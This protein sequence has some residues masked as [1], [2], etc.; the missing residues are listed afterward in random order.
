MSEEREDTSYLSRLIKTRNDLAKES[1]VAQSK[2]DAIV[3][4]AK[5]EGRELLN[6]DEDREFRDWVTDIKRLDAEMKAKDE[7]IAE[8]D[9]ERQRKQ[10]LRA[11][12][13]IAERAK[14][15]LDSVT[16]QAVYT[17]HSSRSYF[18]D[19][20]MVAQGRDTSGEAQERLRRHAQDVM[21]LPEYSEYR[22]GLNTTS[23]TGG[24]TVPPAYLLNEY[25]TYA[26]AGRPF[27][28]LVVNEALPDGTMQ[29]NIP[30]MSTGTT[31]A[32]QATQNT[33]V[34]E[35]D[36][37]DSYVTANVFTVAGQQ[38]VSRQLLE[39]SA[40]PVDGLIFR[41]L[42]AA[43][44]TYLD[45]FMYTGSGTNQIQGINNISGI[46]TVAT[47]G[48]TIGYV[49]AAIAN[50]IQLVHSTRFAS[51]DAILM[52]P[53]RWG[54]LTSL[55]DS[56]NR[57][58]FE[59]SAN[60][61]MNAGG[62]LERVAPEARVGQV[63]GVPIIVDANIPTN[64][65]GGTNQDPIYVVRSSDLVLYES[66]VRAEAF[67]ETFAQNMSVLLQ[68]S[69]YCAFASRYPSSIVEVTGFTP[70]TWGS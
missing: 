39:R 61:P 69:S 35:T 10:D 16:E 64:L 24:S 4:V 36:I 47:G 21:S 23:G 56:T 33:L 28:D 50:A 18:A 13:A 41:D 54:W 11:G 29:V 32:W 59:P 9:E 17:K 52:H 68:V 44:A 67:P 34:N 6:D 7:L 38:T 14:G 19:L 15:G 25:I 31:V 8:L 3:S 20:A 65:G 70:P 42:I 60:S 51:P 2:R 43:H 57:P 45:S 63:Q 53:R 48:L 55:L 26:R 49:Y 30:K 37:T 40:V 12:A 46:Q 22:T 58:L 27:A 62:L 1:D 5:G 66:G